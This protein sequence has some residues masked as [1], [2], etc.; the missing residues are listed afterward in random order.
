[1]DIDPEDCARV[2]G[3][4][5]LLQAARSG[6]VTDN[7]GLQVTEQDVVDWV[8]ARL[9][10]ASWTIGAALGPHA[11][12]SEPLPTERVAADEYAPAPLRDAD[13]GRVLRGLVLPTLRR[14]R[15]AS[16]DRLIR[17]VSRVQPQASRAAILAEL[18][19][20]GDGVRWFGRSIV[21]LE[22]KP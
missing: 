6:E 16:L 13:D 21:C 19:S 2:L 10:V 18:E 22:V 3:L 7:H 15:V 12:L 20:A 14:L 11:T 17:E 5:A 4:A 8:V 1:V 9:D